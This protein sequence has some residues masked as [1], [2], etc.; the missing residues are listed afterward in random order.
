MLRRRSIRTKLVYALVVLTLIFCFLSFSGIWGIRRYREL[1]DSVS[2]QAVEIPYAN[3]LVRNAAAIRRS[4]LRLAAIR[5]RPGM[6]EAS[7]LHGQDLSVE[8]TTIDDSLMYFNRALDTYTARVD[9]GND[10][11]RVLVDESLQQQSLWEIREAKEAIEKIWGH[12]TIASTHGNAQFISLTN[13]LVN[14]TEAHLN[15]IHSEMARFSDDVN[16]Q[17]DR[18]IWFNVVCVVAAVS[19]L[20]L[21]WFSFQIACC[22]T[23]SNALERVAIGRWWPVRAPN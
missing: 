8:Y 17:Y 12:P 13:D 15:L 14:K 3:D 9:A 19:L 21:L 1:A 20:S 2:Q 23:I 6:I 22:T 11:V 7:L 5:D 18:W 16:G 4:Y 10:Q